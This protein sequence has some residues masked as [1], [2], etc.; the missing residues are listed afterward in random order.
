M[1][2]ENTKN[3][4]V[5]V[6]TA[7]DAPVNIAL[8][9]LGKAREIA[10]ETKEE[11]IAVL[12]GK[13]LEKLEKEIIAAGADK[14]VYV[15]QEEYQ[16][17]AYIKVVEE[18]IKK[19]TP[20]LVIA[21][22]TQYAK[23]IIPVVA[24][25]FDTVAAVDVM[26]LRVEADKNI[27]T[28]PVYGGTILNE[29]VIEGNPTFVLSRSGAFSKAIDAA[30]TGEFV[31]E[32]ISISKENLLAK[33]IESVKE[34]TSSVNLEEAEVIVAGGRGMGTKE[35]FALVEELAKICN[36][37]VGA[38]RPAIE[39]EW[40]ERTHQVGQSG[41]IVAPKLYI[42][43]GVSG[44]TQHVSGMIDSGYIIAINKDEDAPI[45]DIADVGIVGDVTKVM[46]LLIEEFKKIKEA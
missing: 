15:S 21:G 9:A 16:Y 31:K 44:A 26:K 8:E 1:K 10:D 35:N 20:R 2:L 33:I 46:P 19:Y 23:D 41:K 14:V 38:T 34:I 5:Y 27:V 3:I 43:C 45:F 12:I 22:G 37:V 30:R 36:G 18:L 4:M 7:N 13:D 40:V 11:V 29:I 28:C 42:A 24:K 25:K 6:E 32:E 17:E 39:D